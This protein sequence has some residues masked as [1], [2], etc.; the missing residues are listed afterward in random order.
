MRSR[1]PAGALRWLREDARQNQ[2]LLLQEPPRR[3]RYLPAL[4]PCGSVCE[5]LE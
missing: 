2:S 3:T 1:L 4:G 5:A